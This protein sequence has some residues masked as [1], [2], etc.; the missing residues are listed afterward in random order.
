M[1]CN[2]PETVL[3]SQYLELND[4][5]EVLI[6]Q[7]HENRSNILVLQDSIKNLKLRP[8][9]TEKQFVEIYKY[10]SLLDYYKRCVKNKS[11]WVNY[12]GWS[13]RVFEQK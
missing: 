4:S 13:T 12:R 6:R 2:S 11:Q 7:I 3:K 8:L 10:E 1:G 5:V 9:M